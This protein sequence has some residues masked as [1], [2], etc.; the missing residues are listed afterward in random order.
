MSGSKKL[1][2]MSRT[3]NLEDLVKIESI[4]L[5]QMDT[6]SPTEINENTTRLSFKQYTTVAVLAF[7]NLFSTITYNCIVPF[8]PGEAQKRGLSTTEVGIIFGIFELCT[9]IV[10][11]LYGKYVSSRLKLSLFCILFFSSMSSVLREPLYLVCSLR[12]LAQ[13]DL[14]F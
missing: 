8:F 5:I 14:D 9:L 2:T 10:S 11:P 6:S 7:A 1:D 12:A 3:K 13:W 4:G